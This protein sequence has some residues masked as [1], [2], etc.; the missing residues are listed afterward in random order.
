MDPYATHLPLLSL[1]VARCT[2]YWPELPILELG[3]GDYSTP[4][5]TAIHGRPH[6]V[7]TA[8]RDWA[9]KY[10]YP[11]ITLVDNW[12]EMMF[13]HGAW[14][15]VFV[16]NEE[17]SRNRATRVRMALPYA[18][19]VMTHDAHV[20]IEA[21]YSFIDDRSPPTGIWSNAYNFLPWLEVFGTEKV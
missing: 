4:V 16:D 21:R 9:A 10:R 8:S 13:S 6:E 1:A 2:E 15:L 3:C 7:W 17:H 20:P 14:S 18:Q 5:I 19:I 12:S 11:R